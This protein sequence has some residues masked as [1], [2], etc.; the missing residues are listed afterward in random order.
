MSAQ[1]TYLYNM[2]NMGSVHILQIPNLWWPSRLVDWLRVPTPMRA[3]R[4]HAWVEV[5]GSVMEFIS[6]K[7]Q[8][9]SG[10]TLCEKRKARCPRM[11]S[12]AKYP[13]SIYED[14]LQS[15][16]KSSVVHPSTVG[17]SGHTDHEANR[18]R[19]AVPHDKAVV[20]AACRQPGGCRRIQYI[21]PERKNSVRKTGERY[22]HCEEK[23]GS[24]ALRPVEIQPLYRI[25]H[26][27][28]AYSCSSTSSWPLSRL[29]P[30]LCLDAISRL[31]KWAPGGIITY[32]FYQTYDEWCILVIVHSLFETRQLLQ[33][34][35]FRLTASDELC[36]TKKWTALQVMSLTQNMC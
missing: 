28:P 35:L 14:I 2:H 26:T 23:S 10:A 21:G 33:K 7:C 34:D 6:K 30:V 1:H 32:Y 29:Y 27:S 13:C 11:N 25:W 8:K 4:V 19:S 15:S 36:M 9:F 5:V 31:G 18:G 16:T 3:I 20:L 22:K 17:K 12:L 24:V